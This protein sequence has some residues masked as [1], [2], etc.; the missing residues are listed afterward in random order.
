MRL[1]ARIAGVSFILL[2]LAVL[3]GAVYLGTYRDSVIAPRPR[4]WQVVFGGILLGLV[5]C[6]AGLYNFKV[7][8]RQQGIGG[9]KKFLAA[10]VRELR[11][12]AYLGCALS[13]IRL[14]AMCFG[15]DWPGRWSELPLVLGIV[16]LIYAT[17]NSVQDTTSGRLPFLVKKLEG[18]V[19]LLYLLASAGIQLYPGFFHTAGGGITHIAFAVGSSILY[20]LE[21]VY[22]SYRE[23]GLRA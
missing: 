14:A 10:H 16:V 15:V 4:D 8:A 17:P 21:A 6:A 18:A 2:G 11:F 9:F 12:V 19:I 7:E 3:I 13:M 20:T 23:S 5:F 22:L 1:A